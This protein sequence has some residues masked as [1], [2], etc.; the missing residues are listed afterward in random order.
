MPSISLHALVPTVG[1]QRS[2]DSCH[3]GIETI[4]RPQCVLPY[5]HDAEPL[6]TQHSVHSR[7]AYHIPPNLRGPIAPMLTGQSKAL[8]A[9]MPKAPVYKHSNL[10]RGEPKIGFPV[11][12]SA[13]YPPPFYALS[14]KGHLKAPFSGLV[15]RR[16]NLAHQA[17]TGFL[18]DRVQFFV[19]Q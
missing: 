18:C 6:P 13:A 4:R 15:T 14:H 7:R 2:L 17:A 9:S 12:V 11:N 10:R 1:T 3:R 5:S 8:R 19:L 16:T